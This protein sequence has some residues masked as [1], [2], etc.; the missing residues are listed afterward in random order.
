M[1]SICVTPTSIAVHEVEHCVPHVFDTVSY[2]YARPWLKAWEM[3]K[4]KVL[5]LNGL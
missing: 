5:F 2:Y 1:T 4:K 3:G